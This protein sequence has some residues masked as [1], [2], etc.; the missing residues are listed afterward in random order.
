VDVLLPTVSEITVADAWF[1]GLDRRLLPISAALQF[2]M[3][4]LGVHVDAFNTWIQIE[5]SESPGSSLLLR[6][7][8]GATSG[9]AVD[10]IRAE[11]AARICSDAQPEPVSRDVGECRHVVLTIAPGH[12]AAT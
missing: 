2:T 11:I 12:L 5:L 4:V 3:Q 1:A 8:H 7:I 10:I 6:L 9:D